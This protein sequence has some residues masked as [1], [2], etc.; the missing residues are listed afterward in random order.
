MDSNEENSQGRRALMAVSD[1][2]LGAAVL[3]AAGVYGGAWLDT[4][5]HTAPWLSVGLSILGGGL[6][7]ARMVVKATELDT[8]RDRPAASQALDSSLPGANHLDNGP[9]ASKTSQQLPFEDLD[10][11]N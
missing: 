2:V 6:G 10:E 11:Q 4:K 3:L 7:L 8:K 1:G 9:G 5:L